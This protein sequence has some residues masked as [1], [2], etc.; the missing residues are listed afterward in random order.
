MQ[1]DQQQLTAN[2]RHFIRE[3]FAT[4]G[5]A[6]AAYL[7]AYNTTDRRLAQKKGS[8]L[9]KK[10]VVQEAIELVRSGDTSVV[11]D[12]VFD[13]SFD[14]LDVHEA[15]RKLLAQAYNWSQDT[16][17]PR[18]ERAEA[19]KLYITI[20]KWLPTEPEPEEEKSPGLLKFI[21][22]LKEKDPDIVFGPDGEEEETV[23]GHGG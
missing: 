11:E 6:R 2:Q 13:V 22:E 20:R 3:Y 7:A 23:G 10:P 19:V 12:P 5:D 8:Q 4:K 15:D 21:R 18:K 16:T 14:D 1:S 9:L 17:L